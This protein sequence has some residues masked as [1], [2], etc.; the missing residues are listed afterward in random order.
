MAAQP[1]GPDFRP[2]TKFTW[3]AMS[4]LRGWFCRRVV[5]QPSTSLGSIRACGWGVAGGGR[6]CSRAPNDLQTKASV[7]FS[8]ESIETR[9]RCTR[10]MWAW[11]RRATGSENDAVQKLDVDLFDDHGGCCASLRRFAS[12]VLERVAQS[13]PSLKTGDV[14]LNFLRPFWDSLPGIATGLPV[15][16]EAARVWISGDDAPRVAALRASWTCAEVLQFAG[17]SQ[18]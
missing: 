14:N 9:G 18:C 4:C 6:I 2:S 3:G 10:T 15:P 11:L 7:P 17:G 13:T 1:M 16:G 5:R 8:L 12:R